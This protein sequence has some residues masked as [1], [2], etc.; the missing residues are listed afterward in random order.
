MSAAAGIKQS[1]STF[2][3]ERNKRERS[4]LIAAI[5]V[6]VLGLIYALLIDPAISGRADL[7]KRLPS[8][9]QQAAEVQALAK[10]ASALSGTTAPPPPP[11]TR[12][13]LETSL[14]RSGLK[15][16]NLSVSN[17]FA[18]VQLNGVP[19]S[20]TVEWLNELRRTARVSVSEAVV[21]AQAES[22]MVNATLT[23]RQQRSQ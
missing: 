6:V 23:L 1:L 2:W 5:V 16:Q 22:D 11:I 8:L 19:F 14:Q 10:E 7:E 3:N 20:G 15:A 17:E 4:M 13:S 12:E 9:R 21:E 18:K